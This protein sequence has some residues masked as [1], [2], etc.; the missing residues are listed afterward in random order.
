M[1]P[2]DKRALRLSERGGMLTLSSHP[3][4]PSVPAYRSPPLRHSPCLLIAV[5]L[6]GG[7]ASQSAAQDWLRRDL[8]PFSFEAPSTLTGGPGRGVDSY[9]GSYGGEHFGLWFDYG[10]HSGHRFT[11]ADAQDARFIK[12][13][14]IERTKIDGRDAWVMT[15]QHDGS[16]KCDLEVALVVE[17]VEPG[18]NLAMMSCGDNESA[19][20][21][22]AIYLSIR[23]KPQQ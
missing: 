19:A 17:Q 12:P 18:K 2:T 3:D 11:P 8:G 20:A 16:N 1:R 5:V 15:G 14:K 21:V 10:A 22:R 13:A 6:F 9:V 7:Y 23:F 4:S